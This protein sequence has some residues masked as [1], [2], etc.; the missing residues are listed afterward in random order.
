MVVLN[1]AVALGTVASGD[2]ALRDDNPFAA[3]LLVL[4]ETLGVVAVPTF[5][6]VSGA[7]LA[8]ASL[9]SDRLTYRTVFAR[10]PNLLFPYLVWS[11]VF[12]TLV[13][14]TSGDT[15]SVAGY[16]KNLLVG[17]PFNFVPLI[18]FFYLLSPILLR[19]NERFG[20]GVIAIV[21][22]YQL[23]LFNLE[24]PG[25]LGFAWPAWAWWLAPKVVYSGLATWGVFFPL[26][27]TY[28][29]KAR[30]VMPA[31]I[32]WRWVL[33]ALVL[34]F[35]GFA[36]LA[37]IHVSNFS[38]APSFCAVLFVMVAPTLRRDLIPMVRRLEAVGKKSYGIYLIHL[39]VLYP[40]LLAIKSLVPWSSQLHIVLIPLLVALGLGIPNLVMSRTERAPLRRAYRYV[41][42]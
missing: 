1:H 31:L 18:L 29:L 11:L 3:G 2:M 6:F 33:W 23:F 41:F 39:L 32:K 13:F 35:F 12:Y 30:S 37:H 8:Y 15:Y 27:M 40:V 10:V 26:G 22:V 7:F 20:W 36:V 28:S 24:F 5:L 42:G 21:G 14:F 38:L 9:G 17:Y 34:F 25:A 19:L 16:V 4:L